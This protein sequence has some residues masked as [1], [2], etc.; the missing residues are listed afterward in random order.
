MAANNDVKENEITQASA[1]ATLANLKEV[2]VVLND[3]SSK[4]YGKEDFL[5]VIAAGIKT[6]FQSIAASGITG[7]LP[8]DSGKGGISTPA[9]AASVLGASTFR[10]L[11]ES[12]TLDC[13]NVTQPSVYQIGDNATMARVTNA[14]N[15]AVIGMLWTPFY[16]EGYWRF[17][18]WIDSSLNCIWFRKGY[19]SSYSGWTKLKNE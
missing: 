16:K 3:G 4:A 7:F 2:R 17:Q 15:G 5:G 12:E 9:D 13:N 11:L 19:S 6:Y 1:Q 14:P 18:L 8:T 10:V